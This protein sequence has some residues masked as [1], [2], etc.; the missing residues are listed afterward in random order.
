MVKLL[1]SLN[2]EQSYWNAGEGVVCGMDEVGRGSWAGPLTIGAVIATPLFL[3]NV[4]DSKSMSSAKREAMVASITQWTPAFAFGEAS[5]KE[6]DS[7]G[8]AHCLSLAASRALENLKTQGY[9]VDKLLLDGPHDFASKLS[10]LKT[11]NVH[12]II[13]GDSSSLSIAAS[14]VLAKVHRDSYMIEQAAAYPHWDFAQSKGYP[15]PK[16]KEGLKT[17][18]LS[19]LHRKSW[20]YVKNLGLSI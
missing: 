17:Y 16:H 15:S 1:P 5:P 6:I 14:S 18:G 7:L 20:A 9:V 19:D 4:Y 8:L 10:Y 3:E 12:T 11:E 2:V 13:K